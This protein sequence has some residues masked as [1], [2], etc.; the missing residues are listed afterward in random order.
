MLFNSIRKPM[1]VDDSG[2]F[3]DALDGFP[4]AIAHFVSKS[5]VLNMLSGVKNRDAHFKTSIC[6][7]D[8]DVAKIFEGT[9]SGRIASE[10]QGDRAFG[11]DSL[12]IPIGEEKTFAQMSIE[13]KSKYS[14]RARAFEKLAKYVLDGKVL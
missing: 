7:V 12:F 8:E 10:P 3:I 14:H 13:E 11:F 4:G 9:V 2:L 5:S 6:Y 1:F